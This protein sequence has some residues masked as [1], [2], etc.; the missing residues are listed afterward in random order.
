M[1]HFQLGEQT[2]QG[3][4]AQLPITVVLGAAPTTSEPAVTNLT[5]TFTVDGQITEVRVTYNYTDP[6]LQRVIEGG[7][8]FKL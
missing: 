2:T 3:S 7:Q 4:K 5:F 1:I 6:E 8:T